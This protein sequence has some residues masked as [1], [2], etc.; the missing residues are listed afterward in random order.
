MILLLNNYLIKNNID[1]EVVK[2]KIELKF[3]I[4]MIWKFV[5]GKL[6]LKYFKIFV[7]FRQSKVML[8]NFGV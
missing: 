3:W 2:N 8:I 7:L 1:L 6:E 5:S 4:K